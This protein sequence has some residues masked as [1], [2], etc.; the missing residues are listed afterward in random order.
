VVEGIGVEPI[1]IESTQSIEEKLIGLKPMQ[2]KPKL[3]KKK[4]GIA[5]ASILLIAGVVMSFS[6]FPGENSQTQNVNLQPT[7]GLVPSAS[8]QVELTGGTRIL[9]AK[10]RLE[11]RYDVNRAAYKIFLD[12]HGF[13]TFEALPKIPSDFGE[14]TYMIYTGKLTVLQETKPEYYLQ[15]EF[16]PLFVDNGLHRFY[17]QYDPKYIGTYGW[18][19]YPSE[20]WLSVQSNSSGQI[21]LFFK[22]GWGIET[23]QGINLYAYS[24]CDWLTPKVENPVFITPPTYPEFCTKQSCGEDW[25]RLITINLDVGKANIGQKCQVMLSNQTPPTAKDKEWL[26]EHKTDYVSASSSMVS[27]GVPFTAHIEVVE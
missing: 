6:F 11:E 7:P 1:G 21:A 12:S 18:G 13:N 25:A 16:Y 14:I 5:I 24:D 8:Q 2:S 9:S 19:V 17:E 10:E 3:S 4:I 20:Q 15:P 23:W 26:Y 22:T 27:I